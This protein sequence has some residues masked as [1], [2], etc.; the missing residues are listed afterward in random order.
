MFI[1]KE[2]W[3][4]EVE[5]PEVKN[6]YQ[7]VFELR[8]KLEG[9]LKIARE[10]LLK[11][12]Q[13]GKHYYDRKTKVRQFQPGCKVPLLLPTDHNKLLMQWKGP[14][15]VSGVVGINDYKVRVKD[16]LKVYHAN[17]SKVYIEQEE[18]LGEAAAAIAEGLVTSI[19]CSGEPSE[20]E[21]DPDDDDDNG[22]LEIGG[23]VAKEFIADVETGPDLN[24]TQR[25]EF[26]NLAQ[27][28]SSLFTEAPRTMNLVQHHINLTSNEPVRSKL[29]PVPYS[30]RESLKKDIDDMMKIGIIRE[31]NSPYAFPVV[32]VK[33]KD[34]SNRVCMDY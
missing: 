24:K 17:L 6:R 23:Y 30:M 3:T 8:E 21:L 29:Y 28:C 2:L 7:Y 11:A 12:Q 18:E 15:K 16:K 33:K 10:E 25:A 32:I 4:K 20:I 13:K 34:G 14:Y 1:L 5:A 27:E 31:S 9:T 19:T 22:F 26:I